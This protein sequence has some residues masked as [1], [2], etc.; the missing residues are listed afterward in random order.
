MAKDPST[1][2]RIIQSRIPAAAAME[3]LANYCANRFTYL[4]LEHWKQEI[5]DGKVSLDGKTV[6]DPATILRG[7][8][9]LSWDG[10][11]I[12]EPPVDEHITILYEDEWFVA[13]DKSGNLPVH[14][15]GRYFNHTLVAILES[16]YGRKVYAAH[17]LDR[18]TSGVI[19]MAFDGKTAGQLSAALSRGSK[20]YQ[21][22][23]H[24]RFPD[25]E[26]VVDL[27]MGYDREAAV[28]KKRRA[29]P[30]GS[31]AALT[32][33]RK[34][35]QAGDVSL[36]RCLPETGRLHQIRA[37]LLAAGYP[38]VGD[39]HYG[40][41]E[42]AFLTFVKLGFTPGLAESLILPRSALHAAGVAFLHPQTQKEMII[43]SP[44][45]EM[46]SDFIRLKKEEK[47]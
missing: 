27:P 45:P 11:G 14:P 18:E 26:L 43:R 36:V 41:D 17:R 5:L 24:G 6:A 47:V 28:K 12:V 16:R 39:K 35:L 1:R 2:T 40:R 20:E 32:R 10:S 25:T 21:A 31:E 30:G 7:G 23:V 37:H 13:V 29:W 42:T 46:F 34:I 38:I 4:T 19:L 33:F 15:A 44:L 22:V 3:R 8:E 9:T